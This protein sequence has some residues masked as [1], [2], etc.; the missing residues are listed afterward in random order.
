STS[1]SGGI[2]GQRSSG[3]TSGSS[4]VPGLAKHASIPEARA[5]LST[6]SAPVISCA[7][8]PVSM[9]VLLPGEHARAWTLS[10]LVSFPPLVGRFF[11]AP[12]RG[13][14]LLCPFHIL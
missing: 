14:W 7:S 4:V 2:V 6:T 11:A 12:T 1:N 3:C 10:Q 13:R 9:A 8:F 5:V